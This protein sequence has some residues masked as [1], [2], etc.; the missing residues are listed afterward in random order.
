ML[1]KM[2]AA[3]VGKQVTVFLDNARYQHC[4]LVMDKAKELGI[5]LA[6]LPPYSPNLNLIERFWK[7]VEKTS[8][9]NRAFSDFAQFRAAI[10]ICIED[11]FKKHPE[12]LKTLLATKFQIIE[13]SQSRA[14]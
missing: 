6:F 14:A 11:A 10:D 13:F 9:T 3:N 5:E 1:M 4:S 2:A 12:E 7:Y 8:L